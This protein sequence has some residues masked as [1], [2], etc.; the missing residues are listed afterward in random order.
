[1][2]FPVELPDVVRNW[3]NIGIAI[4]SALGLIYFIAVVRT[5]RDSIF[6]PVELFLIVF[7]LGPWLIKYFWNY[8]MSTLE[9]NSAQF[10]RQMFAL[11]FEW[12]AV[13]EIWLLIGLSAAS[14]WVALNITEAMHYLN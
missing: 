14:I 10:T 4:N 13:L 5:I 11:H 1:M 9:A 12:L 3:C 2:R 6:S 7:F 8:G